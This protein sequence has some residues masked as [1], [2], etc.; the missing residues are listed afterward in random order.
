MTASGGE[1]AEQA[2]ALSELIDTARRERD[3]IVTCYSGYSLESLRRNIRPG[4]AALLD[5]LDLLID[6]P[7]LVE[8]H[9]S[10]LWRGSS[11][12]RI[13][14]LSGRVDLPLR[15]ESVGVTPVISRDGSVE[16]I[17]VYPERETFDHLVNS[18][19]RR[20]TLLSPSTSPRSFP[21]RTHKEL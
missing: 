11:N 15:D 5:R 19:R 9:A 17:G 12:Q 13:H 14:N 18:L 2:P 10:L 16:F 20:G 21:F 3:W 7:Y 8:Q 1:P 6:G 4:T